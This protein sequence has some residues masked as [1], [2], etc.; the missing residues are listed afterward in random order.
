[1][2]WETRTARDIGCLSIVLALAFFSACRERPVSTATDASPEAL[3]PVC[4]TQTS[5][6]TLA[7]VRISFPDGPCGF[8]LNEALATIMIPYDVVIEVEV[9]GIN[10]VPH[11]CGNT[12]G[13]SGLIVFEELGGGD[14][15]YCICDPGVCAVSPPMFTTLHAGTY[16]SSFVWSGRNYLGSSPPDASG[17]APF[18]SGTYSLSMTSI[19]TLMSDGG[20]QQYSIS[21]TRSVV[22]K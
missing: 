2:R 18:A 5:I 20:F 19:G 22:I 21:A 3:G 9:S 13:P 15:K 11:Y 16:R 8:S 17:G 4:S 10:S 1:M 14:Q 12:P 6:S 7:G